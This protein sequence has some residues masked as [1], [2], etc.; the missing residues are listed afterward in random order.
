M[1]SL[2]RPGDPE[3]LAS[4]IYVLLKAP[5]LAAQLG[6]CAAED[7]ARRYHPDKI[8]RET[9]EFYRSVLDNWSADCLRRM[10]CGSIR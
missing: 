10:A 6:R 8:T 4:A 2:A 5:E 1:G 9:A 3:D 7:A